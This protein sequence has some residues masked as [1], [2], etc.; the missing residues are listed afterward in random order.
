MGPTF[1]RGLAELLLTAPDLRVDARNRRHGRT[2]VPKQ[3]WR[4]AHLSYVLL[5]QHRRPAEEPN[6]TVTGARHV[7]EPPVPD[8]QAPGLRVAYASTEEVVWRSDV[9]PDPKRG[10]A[11]DYPRG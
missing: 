1:D 7:R 10:Q 6:Q 8:T 4:G 3:R 11:P 2:G 9:R 5:T